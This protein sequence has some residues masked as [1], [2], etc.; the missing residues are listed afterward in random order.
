MS[1]NNPEHD[2]INKVPYLPFRVDVNGD[3]YTTDK[4]IM[5]RYITAGLK[6]TLD[7]IPLENC[8]TLCVGYPES[9]GGDAQ[10]GIT[11][12]QKMNES[13]QTTA[14]RETYEESGLAIYISEDTPAI[15]KREKRKTITSFS[16]NADDVSVPSNL[17]VKNTSKD[18][19]NS[20]AQILIYGTYDKMCNLAL[21]GISNL[22]KYNP[23]DISYL[24][25]IPVSTANRVVNYM[26]T[27]DKPCLMQLV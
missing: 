15:V 19:R 21:N 16:V 11:G 3:C 6:E 5:S 2:T 26:S 22:L 10:V 20:K 4:C 25:V 9:K 7:Q 12:S 27:R 24:L 8:Y 13:I 17:I 1:V 18:N 14:M 23:D